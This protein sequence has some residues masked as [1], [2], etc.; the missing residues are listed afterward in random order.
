MYRLDRILAVGGYRE[1]FNYIEDVSLWLACLARGY[2]FANLPDVLVHYR[3]H[4]AQSS[5]CNRERMLVERKKAY[6]IYGPKIWGKR[7]RPLESREPKLARL[8][9]KIEDWFIP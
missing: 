2:C 8:R 7:A 1:E 4:T 5:T 3:V 9:R 6:D